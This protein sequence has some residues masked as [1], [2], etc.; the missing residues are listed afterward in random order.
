[1]LN[2]ISVAGMSVA[3]EL[4]DFIESQVLPEL[5]VTSDQFWTGL[6]KL[7]SD[8][9]VPLLVDGGK[10]YRVSVGQAANKEE[11]N[12]LMAAAKEKG[13]KGWTLKK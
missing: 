2:R 11:Y 3:D 10:L 4:F 6:S 9:F 5:S 7:T 8:G 13:Y 12:S 1:M